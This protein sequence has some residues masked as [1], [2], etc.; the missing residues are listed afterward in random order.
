MPK[1]FYDKVLDRNQMEMVHNNSVRILSEIG[2]DIYNDEALN[3]LCFGQEQ[4]KQDRKQ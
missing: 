2:T 1:N 3:I 4:K